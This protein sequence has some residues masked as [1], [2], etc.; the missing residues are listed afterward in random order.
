MTGGDGI[1]PPG[2]TATLGTLRGGTGA[3]LGDASGGA[4]KRRFWRRYAVIAC[5]KSVIDSRVDDSV[6]EKNTDGVAGACT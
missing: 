4:A 6:G 3:A 1:S 2:T 5:S